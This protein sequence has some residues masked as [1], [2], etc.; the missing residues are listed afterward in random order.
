MKAQARYLPEAT[1]WTARE[2]APQCTRCILD[3]GER[4]ERL[5]DLLGARGVAELIDH[6][7]RSRV[8]VACFAKGLGGAVP[9]VLVD[10]HEPNLRPR[11]SNRMCWA[12]PAESR[13][14]HLVT[15]PHLER[16]E[17]Q[18]ERRGSTRHRN[19]VPA[20]DQGGDRLLEPLDQRPLYQLSRFENGGDGALLVRADPWFC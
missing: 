10:V 15:R 7:R 8:P 1:A 2:A 14:Q 6:D 11:D 3:D 12:W 18:L 9:L 4:P 5:P 17:R 19:G 20:A 16:L 13:A